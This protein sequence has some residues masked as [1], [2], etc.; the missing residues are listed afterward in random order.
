MDLGCLYFPFTCEENIHSQNLPTTFETFFATYIDCSDLYFEDFLWTVHRK[1]RRVNFVDACPACVGFA[2]ITFLSFIH[3]SLWE[4]MSACFLQRSA[5]NIHLLSRYPAAGEGFD[6][7][8]K[9]VS[10]HVHSCNARVE[11]YKTT[12]AR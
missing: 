12:Q 3:F 10:L 9:T 11:R 4:N 8:Y 5:Q 2:V 6:N 1:V 7:I